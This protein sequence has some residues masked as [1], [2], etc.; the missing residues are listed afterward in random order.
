M[1]DDSKQ[2]TRIN[3][4]PEEIIRIVKM[5]FRICEYLFK[6]AA[7][8]L[9]IGVAVLLLALIFSIRLTGL[10][11]MALIISAGLFTAAFALTFAIYRC[12][13]CDTQLN[14]FRSEQ[15]H[16]PSCTPR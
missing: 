3:L 6:A 10:F 9:A 11:G 13:V 8:W 1:P 14:Y 16:C 5:R 15:I 4:Q 2:I 7:G 12:T